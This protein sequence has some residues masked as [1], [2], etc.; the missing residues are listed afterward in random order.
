MKDGAIQQFSD[1]QFFLSEDKDSIMKTTCSWKAVTAHQ[2]DLV[3]VI[4]KEKTQ[5][6]ETIKE[7][8]AHKSQVSVLN[9]SCCHC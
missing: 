8:Q 9:R 1:L 5:L 4:N 3:Q 7:E 2:V 6:E